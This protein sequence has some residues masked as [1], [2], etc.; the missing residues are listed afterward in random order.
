MEV[1]NESVEM[2]MK[3]KSFVEAVMGPGLGNE[4][5]PPPQSSGASLGSRDDYRQ[6]HEATKTCEASG[7]DIPAT[8][9]ESYWED[10]WEACW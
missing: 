5:R 2:S 7:V 6:R 8:L 4:G 10:V 9:Q 1:A 3:P